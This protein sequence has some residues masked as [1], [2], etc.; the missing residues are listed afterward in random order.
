MRARPTRVAIVLLSVAGFAASRAAALDGQRRI[1]QYV[2]DQWQ[3]P[4]GLPQG[5]IQSIHQGRDGYLWVG[6]LEGAARFDGVRFTVFDKGNTPAFRHNDVQVIGEDGQG[7]LWFGTWSG[8]TVLEKGAFRHVPLPEGFT[9]SAVNALAEAIDGGLWIGTSKGLLHHDGTAFKPYTQ[10]D[11]LAAETVGALLRDQAGTVWIG[12]GGGLQ[13]MENG[14][15][16]RVPGPLG[17]D[18]ILSLYQDR[19]GLLWVG[20]SRL[21]V[22]GTR[23]EDVGKVAPQGHLAGER[24][25][26]TLQDRD[27]NHWF[28]TAGQGVMRLRA[29]G[30]GTGWD[31]Y[32]TR[33]GLALDTVISL[34][35]DREGALW[36]GTDGGG[37]ARMRDARVLSIAGR[38][39][40]PD[41]YVWTV[42]QDRH[43]RMWMG[44]NVA[45]LLQLDG[46]SVRQYV[47]P[48][49]PSHRRITAVAEDADGALLAASSGNGLLRLE[50]GALAR[51]PLAASLPEFI[52]A[53][54]VDREGSLWVGGERD[55]LAVAKGRDVRRITRRDGLVH[56]EIRCISGDREGNVWVCTDRGLSR[57]A[58]GRFGRITN[59]TTREGLPQETVFDVLVDDSG[60]AWIG[61]YGGGL[62]RLEKDKI[63]VYDKKVGLFDDV[64]YRILDDGQG[65]LWMSSNRGIFHVS[66]QDLDD[67]AAGRVKAV[68]STVFGL[69][70]GMR[71]VECNGWWQ[72]AG[73]RSRDG[74]LWFPTVKGLAVIDPARMR[75][76]TLVPP[77]VM[78]RVVVDEKAVPFEQGLALAPGRRRLEFQYTALSLL[79]PARVAFRYKLEGFDEAWVEAGPRRSAFYTN[80]PPGSYHFRVLAANNDGLW[81]EQG[82]GFRFTQKPRFTETLWF[83]AL[84]VAGVVL[85]GLGLHRA[86]V[87]GLHALK[88][89]LEK[90]VATHMV[91]LEKRNKELDAAN[92]QLATANTELERLATEDA[93]TGLFNRRYLNDMLDKEWARAAREQSQVGLVLLDIDYFKKLNDAYGHPTGDEALRKV[94]DV[95]RLSIH[96]P[97]DVAARYGG[98]EFAILLPGTHQAGAGI[99]AERIRKSVEALGFPHRDSQYQRVTVSAG[100]AGLH[101]VPG[102]HAS[103][104]VERADQA[105]YLAKQEG[106]N[107]V[108]EAPQEAS[109]FPEEHAPAPGRAA[110]PAPSKP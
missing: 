79:E 15:L 106:R 69:P 22:F 44:S 55:G 100:V 103:A 20:T 18:S 26:A 71:S 77:V 14:R 101:A 67:F 86:Q 102:A 5:S 40:L 12:T 27:G 38:E 74:R 8:L 53:L 3:L 72:P 11:G 34:F 83:Y 31:A 28:A 57:I 17:T 76:N 46:E 62:A 109:P 68:R 95:L 108:A 21:G 43:G 29:G 2:H 56:D 1:T 89:T 82:A 60:V 52:N 59:F 30:S 58:S 50:K 73:W 23:P 66:R 33:E 19:E 6:T 16:A 107:R 42:M 99:L 78:E 70:D 10:K 84:V 92:T 90:D 13:R 80:V 63:T 37:L 75:P 65:R 48:G 98:E 36:M 4:Q 39:G 47:T 88:R 35:E 25:W 105:L 9:D 97:G 51:H 110:G 54:Y 41:E 45:G 93:L 85:A 24:V 49:S 104:L 81:N 87:A 91:E 7:R 96:R 32:G 64:V 61:T 94:A